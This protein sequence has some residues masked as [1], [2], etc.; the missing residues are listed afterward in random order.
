MKIY[1][2]DLSSTVTLVSSPWHK[3]KL[4][5]ISEIIPF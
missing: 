2:T 4:I 1:I 5:N 3:G